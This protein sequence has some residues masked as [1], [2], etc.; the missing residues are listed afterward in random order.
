VATTEPGLQVYDGAK[1]NTQVPGLDGR[2][3]RA[4]AGVALE[5]QNW[6][7]APN[8]DDFPGAVLRPGETYEQTTTFSFEKD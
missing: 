3:Y 1:L 7:D 5:A 4:H 2:T 6:P 8:H